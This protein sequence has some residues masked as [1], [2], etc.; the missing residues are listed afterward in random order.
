MFKVKVDK[1]EAIMLTIFVLVCVT[2]GVSFS[3]KDLLQHDLGAYLAPAE[4]ILTHFEFL[5]Q[6]GSPMA[7]SAPPSTQS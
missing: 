7:F 6:S 1:H 2:L 4:S 3:N 5:N